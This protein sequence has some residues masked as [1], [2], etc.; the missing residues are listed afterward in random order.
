MST[1]LVR[2]PA[3]ADDRRS[4]QK[5]SDC[6]QEIGG[7]TIDLAHFVEEKQRIEMLKSERGRRSVQIRT[8]TSRKIAAML[9]LRRSR[10]AM[11]LAI[12]MDSASRDSSITRSRERSANR[13]SR[14]GPR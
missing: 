2:Q 12:D 1:D 11:K 7:A 10:A 5:Q 14:I 8:E 13:N 3:K 9:Q 6:D 4:R